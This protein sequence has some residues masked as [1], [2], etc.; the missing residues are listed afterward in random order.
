MEYC[1][2]SK[3]AYFSGAK[4]LPLGRRKKTRGCESNKCFYFIFISEKFSFAGK[5]G[6]KSPYFKQESKNR[7]I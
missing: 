6:A 1:S 7:H 3:S 4:N 2:H 5:M